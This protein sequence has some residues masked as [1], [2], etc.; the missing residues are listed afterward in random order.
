MIVLITSVSYGDFLAATLPAWQ[1]ALSTATIRVL[2]SPGDRRTRRVAEEAG[3]ALHR[4]NAWTADGARFNR[5]K[6]L[7]EA[8]RA[9][10]IAELC[11]SIDA[12]VYPCGTFPAEETFEPGVLYG[13][14]RY[15]CAT[16]DDLSAHLDG[17]TPRQA[18][19]LMDVRLADAGYP[20]VDNTPEETARVA[21]AGLGYFQAFRYAGQRFG[22]FPTAGAY[23]L[24]FAGHFAERRALLECYVLHLGPS[25]GKNWSGRVLPVWRA[26]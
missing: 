10:K 24:A 13:C 1:R 6:A 9:A 22:S 12:D 23:D 5:A 8:M 2:T 16:P 4:T 18:L 19:P 15:L 25:R 21:S 20:L 17:R 26:A 11:L 3:V 14:A 7:D